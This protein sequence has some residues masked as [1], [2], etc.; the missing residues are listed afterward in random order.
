MQVYMS[1]C[2]NECLVIHYM[3]ELHMRYNLNMNILLFFYMDA[4]MNLFDFGSVSW[5]IQLL[6]VSM[7]NICT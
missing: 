5:N 7:R 4:K 3:W 1:G 2:G 6:Y